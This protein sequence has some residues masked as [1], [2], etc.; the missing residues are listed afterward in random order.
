M[1]TPQEEAKISLRWREH[2]IAEGYT[3]PNLTGGTPPTQ[4]ELLAYVKKLGVPFKAF[5]IA[6]HFGCGSKSITARISKLKA[7]GKVRMIEQADNRV[8]TYIYSGGA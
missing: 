1:P 5:D 7:A 3:L 2:R 4:G 8:M 6:Y